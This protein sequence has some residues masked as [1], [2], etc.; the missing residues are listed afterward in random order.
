[1]QVF[2]SVAMDRPQICRLGKYVEERAYL[3]DGIQ[4]VRAFSVTARACLV[5]AAICAEMSSTTHVFDHHHLCLQIY[6][7]EQEVF[8][9]FGADLKNEAAGIKYDMVPVAESSG[10]ESIVRWS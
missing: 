7:N 2:E 5:R 1:M 4:K 8:G 10:T 9:R 3:H 6:A